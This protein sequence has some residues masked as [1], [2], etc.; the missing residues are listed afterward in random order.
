MVS[1]NGLSPFK[2]LKI[3]GSLLA[4]IEDRT[5]EFIIEDNPDFPSLFEKFK[6]QF[7]NLDRSKVFL[8][9]FYLELVAYNWLN[10]T[11]IEVRR[12]I[13]TTFFM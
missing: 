9:K 5:R 8:Y 3:Y 13:W 6:P 1:Y 11:D 2:S 10:P 12:D 4:N 7:M